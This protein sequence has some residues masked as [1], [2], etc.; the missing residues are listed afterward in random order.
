MSS[1]VKVLAAAIAVL[2]SGG[3]LP[4]WTGTN[5]ASTSVAGNFVLGSTGNPSVSLNDIVTDG[6]PAGVTLLGVDTLYTQST[7]RSAIWNFTGG[8]GAAATTPGQIGAASLVEFD[9]NSNGAQISAA[10]NA[11]SAVARSSFTHSGLVVTYTGTGTAPTTV[12]FTLRLRLDT[13][14]FTSLAQRT[15]EG[16]SG[17]VWEVIEASV[18]GVGMRLLDTGADN[19]TAITLSSNNRN[20]GVTDS[21][22]LGVGWTGTGFPGDYE[23]STPVRVVVGNPFGLVTTLEARTE[24]AASTALGSTGTVKLGG[25]AQADSTFGYLPT[26]A[27]FVLPADFSISSDDGVIVNGV[28]QAI[29][30]PEQWAMLGAGLILLAVARGRRRD[31]RVTIR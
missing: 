28:F 11:N 29:P 31:H 7:N 23:L 30:E 18:R 9:V 13:V 14:P 26:G 27:T 8:A 3:V 6:T 25:S 1:H 2:Y 17:E 5:S 12:N 22:L 10:R 20:G 24:I 21:G 16:G 19:T 15:G 4:A